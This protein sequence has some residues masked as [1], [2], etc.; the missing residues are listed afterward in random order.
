VAVLQRDKARLYLAEQ[1]A[2]EQQAQVASEVPGQHEQGGWSQMRYQRHIDFHVTEHLKKV[3]D[4]LNRLAQAQA[5]KLALGG[6]EE[7]VNELLEMLPDPIART[8]IGRFP[9]DYKHDT[10]QQIL[11]RAQR[12]WEHQEQFQEDELVDQ[13]FDAAKSD[14]QGV[15]GI[16]PTLSALA[17]EK[18]RTLLVVDGLTIDGCVCAQCDYFFRLKCSRLVRSVAGTRNRGTLP[19]EPWKRPFSREPRQRSSPPKRPGIVYS[20]KAAWE[21]C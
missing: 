1:G 6:T 17:E 21:R 7:I 5:F 20:L 13:V 4:E 15:L 18:V 12:L 14:T 3:V 16:E 10:E 11:Q 2:S 8:V 9:V 19:I